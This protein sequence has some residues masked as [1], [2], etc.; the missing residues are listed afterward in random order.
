[1]EVI[2]VK[3][4]SITGTHKKQTFSIARKDIKEIKKIKTT[5]TIILATA[6]AAVVASA[7]VLID[8]SKGTRYHPKNTEV[9]P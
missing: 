1:M 6:G 5:G 9:N 2:A 7:L 8:Y 4:D 3:A